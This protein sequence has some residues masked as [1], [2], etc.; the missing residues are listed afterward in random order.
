RLLREQA[1]AAPLGDPGQFQLAHEAAS[2]AEELARTSGSSAAVRGEAEEL[3]RTLKEEADATARDRVLLAALLEAS[4]PPR[5]EGPSFQKDEKG[6]M[7]KSTPP[8][9]DEQFREAFRAW[10]L[11]VDATP[12]S[13]AAERLRARPAAVVEEVV[14][15]LDEWTSERRRQGRPQAECEVPAALAQALDDDPGSKRRELRAMLA[16]GHLVRER[17]LGM[18]ALALRPVHVPFD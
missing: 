15:A 14:A 12:T 7:V 1:R 10:G 2:Q 8:S 9:A 4:G 13:A 16:R 3:A 11:D 17:V 18:L 6:R 5:H